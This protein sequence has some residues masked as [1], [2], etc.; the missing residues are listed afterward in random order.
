MHNNQKQ[1]DAAQ[2]AFQGKQP[3]EWGQVGDPQLARLLQ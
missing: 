1:Q 2:A 3:F